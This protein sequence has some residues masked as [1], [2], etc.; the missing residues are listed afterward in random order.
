MPHGYAISN[1]FKLLYN[2]HFRFKGMF[3]IMKR[4]V[5][6]DYVNFFSTKLFILDDKTI[7]IFIVTYV[8]KYKYVSKTMVGLNLKSIKI[9]YIHY[10]PTYQYKIQTFSRP[11][12]ELPA[13]K[14]SFCRHT[15]L[16]FDQWYIEADSF[17]NLQNFVFTT[18]LEKLSRF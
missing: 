16:A 3:S 5:Y 4:E 15:Y 13:K 18:Y 11:A 9:D 6:Q 14:W 7:K 1:Y 17:L 12:L 2:K 10:L 8:I